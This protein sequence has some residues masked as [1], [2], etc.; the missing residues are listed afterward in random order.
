V[1]RNGKPSARDN[2]DIGFPV[3]ADDPEVKA[4]TP[5]YCPQRLA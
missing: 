5:L 3:T 1:H 2:F 4:G